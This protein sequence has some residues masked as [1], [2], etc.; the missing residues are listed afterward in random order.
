MS[1][2]VD[3]FLKSGCSISYKRNEHLIE[4]G[5][6]SRRVYV[7]LEGI[8]RH[9]VVDYL[10]NEKTIR[11]SQENDFF[12]SSNVS[13]WSGTPSYINSQ[14]LLNSRLLY[15][16]KDDLDYLSSTDPEFVLFEKEKLK[17]FIIEKHKKEIS[18]ITKN[19]KDR[20]IEFNEE[21]INLFNRIPH[22]IIASY[23]DMTPETLSRL[24]AQL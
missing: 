3:E 5:D 6:I 7:V 22:H 11:I 15:W 24:R 9:Y 10:G 16:T 23:L 4:H 18:R 1:F 12:Y 14:A 20:L 19:A 17:D 2:K 8:V 13:Y 21:N